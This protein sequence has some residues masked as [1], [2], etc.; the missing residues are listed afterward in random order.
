MLCGSRARAT[1]AS[2]LRPL[3]NDSAAHVAG[4]GYPEN[5]DRDR[6]CGV[7]TLRIAM[8]ELGSLDIAF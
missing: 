7:M 3:M 5:I 4:R 8:A 1:Y 6:S 2:F